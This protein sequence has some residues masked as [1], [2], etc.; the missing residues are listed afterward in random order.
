M[1]KQSH[2]SVCICFFWEAV[3]HWPLCPLCH[4]RLLIPGYVWTLFCPHIANLCRL[5]KCCP[6]HNRSG[7]EAIW[8]RCTKCRFMHFPTG[9]MWT[10][11]RHHGRVSPE[12]NWWAAEKAPAGTGETA[13]GERETAG[14]R[15][16]SHYS[17]LVRMKRARRR[18]FGSLYCWIWSF[19]GIRSHIR[20]VE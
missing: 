12:G 11:L 2:H 5:C 16:R 13:G 3:S 17:W 18:R 14:R 10:R 20:S 7:L 19:A 6:C 1:N 4:C 9:D 15:D 8:T